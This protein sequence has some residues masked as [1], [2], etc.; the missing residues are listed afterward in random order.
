MVAINARRLDG[1]DPAALRV[2]A[3]DGRSR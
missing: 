2:K 1:V 3:I